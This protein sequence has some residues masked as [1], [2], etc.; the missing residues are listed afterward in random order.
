M[1]GQSVHLHMAGHKDTEAR[2][3]LLAVL[4]HLSNESRMGILAQLT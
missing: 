4:F 2:D 1:A 3:A